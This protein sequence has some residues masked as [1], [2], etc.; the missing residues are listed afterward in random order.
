MSPIRPATLQDLPGVYRVCLMTGDAGRDATAR[1]RNPDLLGHLYVGPYVVG[2]PDLASV[3]ADDEGIAGYLLATADT[4]AFEDWAEHHW[5]PPLRR[6]YP[7]T[8][9]NTPD[10]EIIRLIH[11]PA[12]VPDAIVEAY[13]AQLHI[14]LLER[15][16]GRGY[17]RRLVDG[18]LETLRTR[19]SPGVHL[20]VAS[21]NE[22]A[23][24]FY[25][26]LG[27][28]EVHRMESSLLMGLRL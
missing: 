22:N 16:R 14:D 28:S 7:E 2:E 26:H 25:R 8:G 21:E 27:F 1:F 17:G 11:A 12:R 20:D 19:A 24:A 10:D 15:A 4:R 5:W 18:L 23:I 6:Q 3:V 9:G 13:P